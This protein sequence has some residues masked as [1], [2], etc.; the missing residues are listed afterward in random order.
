MPYRIKGKILQQIL[1]D[2]SKAVVGPEKQYKRIDYNSW[3]T[4]A[5]V[6]D[7]ETITLN[8]ENTVDNCI[9]YHFK[10]SKATRSFKSDDKSFGQFFYNEFVTKCNYSISDGNLYVTS[11]KSHN[12]ET[13]YQAKWD[14]IDSYNGDE[15]HVVAKLNDATAVDGITVNK[16]NDFTALEGI[17]NDIIWAEDVSCNYNPPS[18]KIVIDE[19]ATLEWKGNKGVVDIDYDTINHIVKGTTNTQKEKK[20]MNNKMFNFEFG[21]VESSN[22]VRM[23]MYG[24]AINNAEGSYVA[25]DAVNGCLMNVDIINFD[26]SKFLYKMPVAVKD[27]AVGDIVYHMAKPMFVIKVQSKSLEV[28]DP[29][30]GE[31]K[32]IMLARSPFGFDFATK[33]VSLL[34]FNGMAVADADN[35]F[36]NIWMLMA[37]S[38]GKMDDMMLPLM[39]MNGGFNNMNPMMMYFMM[40]DNKDNNI[41]PLLM[42]NSQMNGHNHTCNCCCGDDIAK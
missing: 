27:I 15:C 19:N 33:L 1:K 3:R 4:L 22:L 14:A 34:N 10:T 21:P 35:P 18:K 40:K 20:N 26:G 12:W 13:T 37:M 9:L 32:E 29:V 38:D 6:S 8:M 5:N 28:I 42:M 24:I 2:F 11:D 30:Y 7:N 23:S 25:W 36:G 17:P 31:K 16:V 39:M 41:L